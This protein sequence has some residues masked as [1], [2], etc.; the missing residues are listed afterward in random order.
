VGKTNRKK[1]YVE[2]DVTTGL[3]GGKVLWLNT[4]GASNSNETV[5]EI[6]TPLLNTTGKCLMLFHYVS[7]DDLLFLLQV[8]EE[9]LTVV[10]SK[11]LTSPIA[12]SEHRY[13]WWPYFFTLP[14][15]LHWIKLTVQAN[16]LSGSTK[17]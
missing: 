13:T 2:H 17:I 6:S 12:T 10:F 7:H 5:G 14:S 15:G 16:R 8:V 9:N 4:T 11:D 1:Y 3:G